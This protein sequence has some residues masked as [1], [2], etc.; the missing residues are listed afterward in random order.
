MNSSEKYFKSRSPQSVL[1]T[2]VNSDKVKNTSISPRYS[3]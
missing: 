3:P 2:R 1:T